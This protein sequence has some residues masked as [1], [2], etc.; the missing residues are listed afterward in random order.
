MK[1]NDAS[2]RFTAVSIRPDTHKKLAEI[3]ELTRIPYCEMID[4]FATAQLKSLRNRKNEGLSFLFT[5]GS[6]SRPP[7]EGDE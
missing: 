2:S 6:M 5:Q 4:L 1:K 7:L 3:R